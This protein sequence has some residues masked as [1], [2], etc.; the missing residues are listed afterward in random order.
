[1][2]DVAG[3]IL[4]VYFVPDESGSMA[5]NVGDLN[6]GL[7][8]LLD[9]MHENPQAADMI[10]FSIIGFSDS[11]IEHLRLADLRDIR[12]MPAL[13]ARNGTS[14]A[15]VFTDL[16]I[17]I[18]S[19]V[20]ELRGKGYEVHRP[21][22][23]FLSDGQPTNPDTEWQAALD[24]LR[25]DKFKYHPNIMAFGFRDAIPQVLLKVASKQEFAYVAAKGAD[26]GTALVK[27]FESLTRSVV[28]SGRALAE[29]RTELPFDKPD[30]FNLAIEL[31]PD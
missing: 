24:E 22:I 30:G 28:D 21:V 8:A 12:T 19:D 18:E 7:K 9:A 2:A 11:A 13:A 25:S 31:L 5:P 6:G 10:R 20:Q 26:T 15:A 3:K 14:Y 17:R 23:F 4:L 1:M 29:G 16:R 27:F